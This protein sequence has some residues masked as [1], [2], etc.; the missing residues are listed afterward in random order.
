MTI[1][2]WVFMLV[3]LAA[4]ILLVGTCYYKVLTAPPKPPDEPSEE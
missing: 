1:G 3:S 2:G 4:V